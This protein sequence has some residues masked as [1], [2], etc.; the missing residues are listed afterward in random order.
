MEQNNNT[1]R[2]QLNKG[3]EAKSND[4]NHYQRNTSENGK[5]EKMLLSISTRSH[6]L[7]F[8]FLCA[9]QIRCQSISACGVVKEH[10]PFLLK[11]VLFFLY[12]FTHLVLLFGFLYSISDCFTLNHFLLFLSLSLTFLSLT[13]TRARICERTFIL[14]LY[15]L[16]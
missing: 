10:R 9:V 6:P 14:P 11:L 12:S 3:N 15:L 7:S 1:Q 8:C 4:Q 13:H 16:L 5:R 2:Q